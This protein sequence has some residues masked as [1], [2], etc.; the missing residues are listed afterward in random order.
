MMTVLD[1]TL[2]TRIKYSFLNS[3]ISLIGLV[4][5]FLSTAA[6]AQEPNIL[7]TYQ[8]TETTNFFNCGTGAPGIPPLVPDFPVTLPITLTISSQ[9]G[10]SFSGTGFGADTDDS[11]IFSGT[12]D[13]L[14]NVNGSFSRSNPSA[15]TSGNFSGTISGSTFSTSHS[16]Q[17][18]TSVDNIF[19]LFTG[20]VTLTLV[21]GADVLITNQTPSSSAVQSQ[22]LS[23][24]VQA[25]ATHISKRMFEAVQ[26]VFKH[27]AS[28]T[29]TA[30]G[31]AFEGGL[32]G[33][34]AGDDAFPFGAWVSYSYSDLSSTAY[35]GN[36]HTVLGGIDFAPWESTVLGIAVGYEDSDTDTTFNLGELETDGYTI[37]P[38][39][40]YLFTDTWSVNFSFGYSDLEYDQFRT[41][42]ITGGRVTSSPDADRWF[43]MFNLNGLTTYGNWILG[44]RVGTLWAKSEVD[45]FV[46]SDTTA[47]AEA[48]SKLGTWSIGGDAAYS[49]GEFEPFVSATYEYDYSMTEI[50]VTT[51]PQPDNDRDDVLFAAGLR[52]FGTNNGISG[53]LNWTRRLGR[54]N[55]DEDIFSASIRVDF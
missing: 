11:I 46:E 36:R 3:F 25:I 20:S 35:D 48:R 29:P 34:N 9:S 52:Y 45:A 43:G 6:Y 2:G 50:A 49:F 14:G 4:L 40:G 53:N 21:S 54:E 51:G 47:V 55:F 7:G 16:G 17:T 42:P 33:L 15:S 41:D 1:K 8:G 13:D 28:I 44:G 18:D 22:N 37:A 38:Y 19:C 5:L 30:N 31:L 12:V 39:F 23:S 10:T 24:D 27:R 26:T 32:S